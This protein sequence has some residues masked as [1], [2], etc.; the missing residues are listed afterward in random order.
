MKRVIAVVFAISSVVLVSSSVSA[1]AP[2]PTPGDQHPAPMCKPHWAKCK[3]SSE[4]C[5]HS[6]SGTCNA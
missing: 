1:S 2:T 6:C 3:F 5:S 4:C